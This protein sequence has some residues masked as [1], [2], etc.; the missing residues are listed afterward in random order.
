[1]KIKSLSFVSFSR[2]WIS[3][4]DDV[5]SANKR[6][7]QA[8]IGSTSQDNKTIRAN[9]ETVKFRCYYLVS[10]EANEKSSSFHVDTLSS[11]LITSHCSPTHKTGTIFL[12]FIFLLPFP[13]VARPSQIQ[14]TPKFGVNTLCLTIN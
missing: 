13:F 6:T 2:G 10:P 3:H 1:M 14:F 4:I 7:T 11:C 5:V 8:V 9:A 12:G